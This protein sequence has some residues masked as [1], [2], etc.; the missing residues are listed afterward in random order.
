MQLFTKE[1]RFFG[2]PEDKLIELQTMEGYLQ[3]VDDVDDLPTH[4]WQRAVW[5]TMENPESSWLARIVGCFSVS[6]ILVSIIAFCVETIPEYNTDDIHNKLSTQPGNNSSSEKNRQ[7]LG[8]G[9]IDLETFKQTINIIEIIAIVWFTVEYLIRFLSSHR[10][11]HFF[12]SFLNLIDLAAILPYYFM[13][14]VASKQGSSI[15]VIRVARLV[16]VF[17]VFKLSRHSMGLQTLGNTLKASVSEL[18]MLVF[19]LSFS[20]LVFSS[21]MYYA[22]HD[23]NHDLFRSIPDTFWYT[24]VSKSKKYPQYIKHKSNI[25]ENCL[26]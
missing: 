7:T 13:L 20:V 6:V 1:A 5:T 22:E 19:I 25:Y 16:R 24:V 10:K 2:I 21:A 4:P 11:W 14:A 23:I 9:V 18:G 17:R 12:R 26:I 3:P 15:A 8:G